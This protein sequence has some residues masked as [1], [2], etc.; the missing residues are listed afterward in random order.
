[1]VFTDGRKRSI[2]GILE[3][4]KKFASFS[5]LNI[6]LEKS[7]L[8]MA[9]LIERDKRGN[10]THLSFRV[11]PSTGPVCRAAPVNKEDDSNGLY[12]TDREN[13]GED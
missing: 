7:T 9:G 3:V 11:W 1:M 13:Q 2:E 8:F 12:A 10:P 5:G 6:S 4:F